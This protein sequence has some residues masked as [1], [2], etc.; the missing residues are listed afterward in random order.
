MADQQVHH[1][2]LHSSQTGWIFYFIFLAMIGLFLYFLLAKLESGD[3]GGD[4][5]PY[6]LDLR[7]EGTSVDLKVLDGLDIV[8]TVTGSDSKEI[9]FYDGY[10]GKLFGTIYAPIDG[11]DEPETE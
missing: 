8:A 11:E 5:A 1:I 2:K 6:S 9:R 10:T 4:A 3:E 7:E